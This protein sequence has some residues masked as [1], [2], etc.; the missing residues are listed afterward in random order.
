MRQRKRGISLAVTMVVLMIFSVLGLAVGALGVTNLNQIR[1]SE[2]SATLLHAANGGLNELMDRL[3]RQPTYGQGVTDSSANGGGTYLTSSGIA[4]YWWTFQTT[5]TG[6]YCVNNLGSASMKKGSGGALVPP[7]TA[8][9]MVNADWVPR[10]LSRKPLTLAAI[11][12]KKFRFALATDGE[13]EAR[14]IKGI[15]GYPGSVWSNATGSSTIQAT[16]ID[17][18][19]FANSSEGAI[20]VSGS[21]AGVPYYNSG[22]NPI[23]DIPIPDVIRS[24]SQL[25]LNHPYGGPA[26][27]QAT[28]PIEFETTPEGILQVKSGTVYN[29][30]GK[31]QLVNQIMPPPPGQPDY[32]IFVPGSVIFRGG[33]TIPPR[34]HLFVQGDI[35]VGGNLTQLPGTWPDDNFFWATGLIRYNGA[36]GSNIHMFAGT[37]VR[38]NGSAQYSGI[39]YVRNGDFEIQGGGTGSNYQGAVIVKGGMSDGD[40][41]ANTANFTYNP[42][43]VTAME[44][45]NVSFS[46]N[47]PVYALCWWIVR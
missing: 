34:V 45:F 31:G 28:G 15:S 10:E 11:A 35:T 3:Y 4:Y 19:A 16:S 21:P 47:T 43:Y 20:K 29:D 42:D 41:E 40:L 30:R 6:G 23:P 18:Q 32:E 22:R 24:Q 7:L 5:S 26:F 36:Q 27:F 13:L 14:N 8:A 25:E 9:L 2:R 39:V 1:E 44:R 46:E 37:G 38:Q 33:A 17:G 12:S